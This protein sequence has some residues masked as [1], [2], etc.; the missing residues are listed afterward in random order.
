MP[1]PIN[2][3]VHTILS[4]AAATGQ[5]TAF[6]VEG[7]RHIVLYFA[8][9]GGS[10]AA[11]TAKVQGSHMVEEP[12]W[13]SQSVANQWDYI[14]CVDLEDGSGVDGDD[15]FVV[16][17]ADDYRIFEVNTNALSWINID[18]TARTEGELTVTVRAFND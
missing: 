16:A 12:T 5:G 6:N 7:Y 17:T 14:Q 11:L 1:G 4:A 10:D 3:E 15:G 9:D 18:V 8:T 13:S 2:T